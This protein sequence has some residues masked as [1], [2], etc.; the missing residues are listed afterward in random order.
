VEIAHAQEMLKEAWKAHDKAIAK[1]YKLLRSILPSD[2]Q[3]QWDQVYCKMHK[4]DLWDK[5]NG[6]MTTGRRPCLWITFQDCLKLHKLTVFTADAAKRQQFY[7]Q[8]A[9]QKH[10]RATGQQHILQMG[11]IK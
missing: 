8:Q 2:S 10:Q 7:I 3:S 9:V 1:M 6:Q 11:S 4:H 5:V